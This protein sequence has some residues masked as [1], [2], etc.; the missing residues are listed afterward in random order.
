[1]STPKDNLI[2]CFT[3]TRATLY[4]PGESYTQLKKVLEDN[5]L[6]LKLRDN[7]NYFCFDNEAFRLLSCI[8]ND[9]DMT[10]HEINL[11]SESWTHSAETTLKMIERIRS[12]PP[13]DTI[14]TVSMNEAKNVV[15]ILSMPMAEICQVL[16]WKQDFRD[17]LYLSTFADMSNINNTTCN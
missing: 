1:M 3:H 2:F 5:N 10:T 12:N 16:G 9:I 17:F 14:K 15:K 8:K 4:E 11:F 7:K 6:D 13:H